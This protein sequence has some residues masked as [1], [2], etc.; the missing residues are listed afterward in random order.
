MKIWNHLAVVILLVSL[1]F[2]VPLLGAESSN[3]QL[4]LEEIPVGFKNIMR[5][6]DGTAIQAEDKDGVLWS[7]DGLRLRKEK[8]PKRDNVPQPQRVL[9]IDLVGSML[10]VCPV[11]NENE[12]GECIFI[13]K[14]EANEDITRAYFT[15]KGIFSPAR[16][17]EMNRKEKQA[18]KQK[19]LEEKYS[20]CIISKPSQK[21]DVKFRSLEEETKDN[22]KYR[23]WCS[24]RIPMRTAELCGK[25]LPVLVEKYPDNKNYENAAKACWVDNKFCDTDECIDALNSWSW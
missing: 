13:E 17:R 8:N 25:L 1:F 6:K 19:K 22:I 3:R 2:S 5:Y 9:G 12:V 24:Y 4:R 15:K 14:K 18:E 7:F 20:N 11:L 23:S 16:I 21:C 10:T